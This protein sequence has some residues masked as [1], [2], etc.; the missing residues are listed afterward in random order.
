MRAVFLGTPAFALPSLAAVAARYDVVAAVTQVDR[1]RDRK[2]N[3]VTCAVGRAAEEA[4][5]PVFRFEKIRAEGAA[6]LKELAPDLMITCAYGQILSKEILD[7]PKYGTLNVHG[8]LLPLYRGS[9]PIQRALINGERKTGITIMRTDVGM[10]TGDIVSARGI[11]IDEN[12]YLPELTAK[13]ANLG[14]ELLVDTIDGYVSGK[15]VPRPQDGAAATYA[16]PVQK[17]EAALD[18]SLS[19]AEIRN[20]VRGMGYGVFRLRG[21]PVKVFRLDLAENVAG[22]AA[23]EIIEAKSGRLVVACGSGAL[24]LTELQSAGKRRMSAADFLNGTRISVGERA[25]GGIV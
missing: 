23:G 14:A 13:L 5:I 1:E 6:A 22:A 2:G 24:A 16:P 20:R 17:S 21:E 12:D 10:D 3:I 8:S 11:E 7:I 25:E 9:A 4:G 15:I 18:F 19:A